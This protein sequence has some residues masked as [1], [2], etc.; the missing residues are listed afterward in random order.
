MLIKFT[1][2]YLTLFLFI[3]FSHLYRMGNKKKVGR[4]KMAKNK[5]KVRFSVTIKPDLLQRIDKNVTPDKG[6]NSLIEQT[7]E[8][9][10]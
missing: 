3:Y 4:P 1:R 5:R 10:F 9:N 6:R 7:L 2:K 8:N